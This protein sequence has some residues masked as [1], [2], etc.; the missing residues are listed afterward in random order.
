MKLIDHTTLER[1]NFLFKFII[2]KID[3]III[4]ITNHTTNDIPNHIYND[5]AKKL[6]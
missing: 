5:F 6:S 4:N 3:L 2:I 1:P